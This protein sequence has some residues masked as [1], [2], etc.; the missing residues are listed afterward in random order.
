[1]NV[2]ETARILTE[3]PHA[4]IRIDGTESRY[5]T[6]VIRRYNEHDNLRWIEVVA[7]DDEAGTARNLTRKILREPEGIPFDPDHIGFIVQSDTRDVNGTGM[8]FG[9]DYVESIVFDGT[10]FVATLAPF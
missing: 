3:H 8:H 9:G 5:L 4:L 7:S 2:T 1:M 10:E 6:D